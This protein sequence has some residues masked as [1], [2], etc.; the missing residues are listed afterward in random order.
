MTQSG[1]S[2]NDQAA[3]DSISAFTHDLRW[4]ITHLRFTPP[5]NAPLNLVGSYIAYPIG[6]V[7]LR[8]ITLGSYPSEVRKHN[9]LF[10]AIFPWFMIILGFLV[11][12]EWASIELLFTGN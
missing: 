12:D 1:R 10:V 8:I 3:T 5:E 7:M 2:R 6:K 4:D 9:S 11:V